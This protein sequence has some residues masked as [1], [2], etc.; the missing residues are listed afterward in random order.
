M[1][2][3][4]TVIGT[5]IFGRPIT[6]RRIGEAPSEPVTADDIA[7]AVDDLTEADAKKRLVTFLKRTPAAAQ[8]LVDARRRR[9]AKQ[10]EPK[11]A[12]GAAKAKA[13]EPRSFE[14][15]ADTMLKSIN[16]PSH[17]KKGKWGQHSAACDMTERYDKMCSEM[18]KGLTE[19]DHPETRASVANTVCVMMV[20]IA[21]SEHFM[22]R[23][24]LMNFEAPRYK[25]LE[26]LLSSLQAMQE[27]EGEME[28]FMQGQVPDKFRQVCKEWIDHVDE[29]W[30][31]V[32]DL[33]KAA[34]R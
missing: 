22:I 3:T 14:H 17:D 33:L 34:R 31:Q 6:R 7:A 24:T 21:E 13:S 20:D 9:I 28:G 2:P 29:E 30:E 11:P 10:S 32:V 18:L 19:S 23:R 25:M 26:T 4:R 12:R 16:L 27:H 8:K 1:P 15:M 5:D